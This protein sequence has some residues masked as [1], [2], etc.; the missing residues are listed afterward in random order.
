MLVNKFP[1]YLFEILKGSKEILVNFREKDQAISVMAY[2][3]TE[4]LKNNL[5]PNPDLQK[6]N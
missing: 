6:G 2:A 3:K 5:T 4:L 1:S